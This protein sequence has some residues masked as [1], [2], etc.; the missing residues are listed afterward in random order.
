M[1]YDRIPAE[2]KFLPQWVVWKLEDHGGPKPTKVPYSPKWGTKASVSN[3][4]SWAT[5][6]D[7][8]AALNE[9]GYS[10]LGFV[11]TYDDPYTFV[12]LDDAHGDEDIFARQQKVFSEL[13]SYAERSPSGT[14]LHIIC[15]GRVGPPGRKRAQIEVYSGDR[16]MTMTGEVYRDAPIV[17]CQE[18]L[19]ILWQQ[20]GGPAQIHFYG[21]DQA[22]RDEDGVII[23]RAMEALN[24]DKFKGLY[25]GRWEEYYSSQSEA[26]FALVDIITFYSQNREQ[27]ARIFRSSGLGRRDKAKR[28]DYVT[29]MINRAFDRQLPPLDTTGLHQQFAE[30]LRGEVA[31]DQFA[32]PGFVSINGVPVVPELEGN[33]GGEG[34]PPPAL[35]DTGHGSLAGAGEDY[36][37]DIVSVNAEDVIFPPGLVGEVARFIYEAAPRPVRE[38]ALV[39]A[40][41]FVA[42]IVGRAYNVSATGLNIYALCLA[43][44]GTGK[45]AIN[46]GVMKL[47]SAVRGDGSAGAPTVQ[48]FIGPGDTRSDAA[49]IKWLAKHPCV[50]SIQGEWGMR[51]K[52]MAAPNAN[53]NEI[54]VKRVLMDLYNKSG[55][56]NILNPLAYSD[57]DKNTASINAPAYTL[58]GESTPERFYEALD[59]AMIADGLLPRFLTIEY[60]G[61][62]PPSS[63]TYINAHPSFALIDMCRQLV[64]HVQ[65]VMATNGVINVELDAQA[66]QLMKDFD[67]YCDSQINSDQAREV[68]RHM[69]NRAH[70]KALKIAALVA[71]GVQPYNPTIDRDAAQWACDLVVRDTLNIVDRFERGEIGTGA[72]QA[73]ERKQIDDMVRVISVWMKGDGTEAAKYGMPGNMHAAGVILGSAITKRLFAM[74]SFRNDRMGASN[75]VKRTLQHLLD[76]DELRE[77]PKSQMASMFGTTA[78]GFM[79]SRPSTFV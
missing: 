22:Q 30:M 77:L 40:I 29:N 52:Q 33:G 36:A 55:H 79:I 7:A 43:P 31:E 78:R 16:F 67:R 23:G 20:L 65:Q 69:W 5:Y 46:A 53:S 38:I 72:I 26:D 42:G 68:T 11:L 51:L 8:I 3:R 74:A 64:V 76:G 15:K 50:F 59:E 9:G 24:G 13:A 21:A 48:D 44:T 12:D 37:Q 2:L 1:T 18:T 25:E 61:K 17:D 34:P 75:A 4:A 58:I 41:G 47:V 19:S 39:G 32:L 57:K 35:R 71:V 27:I 6:D 66:E 73:N 28:N 54:G 63:T 10:G 56:G 70:V 14:G 60:K 49:L 62:R 45:E